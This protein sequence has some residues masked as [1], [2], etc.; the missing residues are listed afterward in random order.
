MSEEKQSPITTVTVFRFPPRARAWALAQMAL[1]RPLLRHVQGLRFSRL[2]GS[3]RGIGF[4]LAPDWDRYALLAVWNSRD[5]AHSFLANSR[6]M[7]RYGRRAISQWS[8]CL[9]TAAAH[10]AWDGHNPFLPAVARLGDTGGRVA[11]LTR[12]TIRPSR[13]RRFWRS[14]PAVSAALAGARGLQRSIGIGELPFVR[15][16]TLSVWESAEAVREFAYGDAPHRDVVRRTRDER[17]Y[18]EDLF[19]RFAVLDEFGQM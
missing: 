1:A 10:G 11:V 5:D 3:G 16:A 18:R 19:A 9:Q 15:Q 6:F 17:W 12:A 8:V 13:L 14:V 2:M 7:R 4:T